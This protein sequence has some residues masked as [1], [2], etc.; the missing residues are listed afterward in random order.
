[1]SDSGLD[2]QFLALL[3]DHGAIVLALLRRLCRNHHDAEDAFQ[4][5]AVRVWCSLANEPALC[6][7]RAW[8]LTIAYR[9]YLD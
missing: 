8:L 2:R 4:D 5:T 7:P 6:N 1:M 9:A 3:D